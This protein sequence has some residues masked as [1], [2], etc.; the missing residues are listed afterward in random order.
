[1]HL[2]VNHYTAL[3]AKAFGIWSRHTCHSVCTQVND[4]VQFEWCLASSRYLDTKSYLG[5]CQS[6]GKAWVF[7]IAC[8]RLHSNSRLWRLLWAHL[9]GRRSVFDS[10]LDFCRS[11]WRFTQ[12]STTC[13]THI[14]YSASI[15]FAL[16]SLRADLCSIW[17]RCNGEHDLLLSFHTSNN[18]LNFRIA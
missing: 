3:R 4:L 16:S 8:I 14:L 10:C 6:L 11:G 2:A 9:R 18:F 5:S 15:L 17:D 13:K 7:V 1:M 12:S